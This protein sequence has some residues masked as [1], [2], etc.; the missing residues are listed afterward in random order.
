MENEWPRPVQACAL[1]RRRNPRAYSSAPPQQQS[2]FTP[3]LKSRP[4]KKPILKEG[5]KYTFKDYFDLSSPAEEVIAEL[6]Y[7]LALG[8]LDLPRAEHYDTASASRLKSDFYRVLPRLSLVS[9]AAKREFLVAPILFEVAK[10]TEARISVEYPLEVDEHLSGYIDYLIRA[11]QELIVIEAKKGDID[12]GF[13]Q[14]AAE[15][16]A[17]DQAEAETPALLYGA[18]TIGEIWRF[19][20]LDRQAKHILRDIHSYAIPEDLERLLAVLVGITGTP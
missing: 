10:V 12:R 5:R 7:S 20:T 18:I 17:L 2:G 19:A 13:T 14:L 11:Q 1:L 16:I 6:G 8:I 9:E 15:L 4:M 3:S